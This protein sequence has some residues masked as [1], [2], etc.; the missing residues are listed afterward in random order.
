MLTSWRYIDRPTEPVRRHAG[1]ATTYRLTVKVVHH[2]SGERDDRW[3]SLPLLRTIRYYVATKCFA[4]DDSLLIGQ[5]MHNARR[6]GW[7]LHDKHCCMPLHRH[8]DCNVLVKA[9]RIDASE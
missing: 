3:S 7:K 6:A 9:T 4:A 8:Q 5:N 1:C 2:T